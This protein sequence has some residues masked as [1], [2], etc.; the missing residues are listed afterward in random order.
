MIEVEKDGQT[1]PMPHLLKS[2]NK[3]SLSEIHE[4]I[5]A[6]Q[7]QPS[8]ARA[9]MF[10]SRFLLVPGFLRHLFYWMVMRTPQMFRQYSSPVIVTAV[11]M[12]GSGG[13]WGIPMPSQTLTVTIGGFSEKPGVVDGRIEVRQFVHLTVSV[14][15]D[16][17]DGAPAARFTQQFRELLESSYG[18]VALTNET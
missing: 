15:H 7:K 10:M 3:R 16:I 2:V 12:F 13:F 14:D 1:V 8:Q 4:E 11:G 17:V 6:V 18:L 5:R 9:S